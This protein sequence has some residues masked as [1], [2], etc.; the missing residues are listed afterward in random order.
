MINMSK[1][2]FPLY[3][4]LVNLETV[5]NVLFAEAV[6][7]LLILLTAGF[8]CAKYRRDFPEN[9]F[10]IWLIRYDFPVPADP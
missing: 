5:I 3:L 2:V 6:T 7:F 1:A 9:R 8:V 10:D 4:L